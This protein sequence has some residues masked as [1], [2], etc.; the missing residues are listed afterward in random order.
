MRQL[1]PLFALAVAV[2]PAAAGD[3]LSRYLWEKRPIIIFAD[4][5]EDQL[6]RRQ[7][8]L[9]AEETEELEER[10]V[11]VLVDT[12]PGISSALRKELRPRG[13][14]LVLVGKDGAVKLRKS[15]PWTVRE[16]SRVIDKMPTRQQEIRQRWG[17]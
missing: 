16:L 10:D 6:F 2:L 9:L 3:G 4:S 5:S 17:R 1:A 7:M 11:V 15:R 13:F 14:Q 8:E 12:D